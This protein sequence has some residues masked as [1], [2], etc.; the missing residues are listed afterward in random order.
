MR[1]KLLLLITLLGALYISPRLNSFK[2]AKDN[3][4]PTYHETFRPGYHFSPPK[5][6]MN[7][8]NGLIYYD[9]LYHMYY[10]Y[11][12][13]DVIWGHMSWGHAVSTDLVSWKNLP[14]AIPEYDGVQIFSGCNIID[15]NNTSGFCKTKGL[16]CLLAFYTA[17]TAQG[18]AQAVAYSND[19]GFSYTQYASNPIIDE[20]L[21]DH[22]DPKV[23]WYEPGQK[24]V[25]ITALSTEFKCRLYSSTDLVHWT[26]LSD[27]GP[28][29]SLE[30]IW[31]DPDLFALPDDQGNLKWVLAHAV[32]V[33]KVEYYIGEFDGTTFTNTETK[34][35]SLFYDYGRDFSEAATWTNDPKGRRLIMAWLDEGYY[36]GQLPTQVWRGQLTMI[37]E[38]KIKRYPEGLRIVSEPLEEYSKLRSSPQH[39]DNLQLNTTQTNTTIPTTGN[40]LEIL[41][42]FTLPTDTS[43]SPAEFGFQ[44]FVG[45]NQKTTIGYNVEKQILFTDRTQSGLTDFSPVFSDITNQTLT[46][47]NNQI[48]LR[49]FI[50]QCSVEVFA[51][52]GK[53]VMSNLIFPDPSQNQ[54]L[55]YV[56]GG[57]VE[58]TSLDFWIINGIWG[59]QEPET[60]L[61]TEFLRLR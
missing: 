14:V 50:D 59:N 42:V 61:Q 7:D 2:I 9:G 27:F 55:A 58:I 44:V 51:N 41:A 21:Q 54:V 40:Q 36:G 4:P 6:W 24:W 15:V 16:G 56:V 12:P 11:N 39:F 8:P 43:L 18:Q 32:N 48:Q 60:S 57:Q 5:N 34:G 31:E 1:N 17:Q 30:G 3:S 19:F 49:L 33:A 29:G 45:P 47:E 20:H 13:Y 22:R 35:V 46:P 28:E 38:L 25:M 52:N 23:I 53:V 37:R 10:Q 26:H